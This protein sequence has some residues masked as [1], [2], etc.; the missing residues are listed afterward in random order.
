MS[1]PAVEQVRAWDLQ[2]PAA[3]R[4]ANS[5]RDVRDAVDECFVC[6]RPLTEAGVARGKWIE[7]TTSG[8]LVPVDAPSPAD[9]Q[10]CFP[11][12]SEC[13]KSIPAAFRLKAVR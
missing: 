6:A 12:G 9:S 4:R 2:A 11:V 7:H 3:V 13:A 10:G 8:F 1:A 5:E